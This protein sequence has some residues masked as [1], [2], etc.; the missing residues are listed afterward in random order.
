M[1]RNTNI[2]AHFYLSKPD[3]DEIC[4]RMC[5]LF[6][7]FNLHKK[8][9]SINKHN[10]ASLKSDDWQGGQKKVSYMRV[11]LKKKHS[12]RSKILKFYS[13]FSLIYDLLWCQFS[14]SANKRKTLDITSNYRFCRIGKK[15]YYIPLY[16]CEITQQIL[17]HTIFNYAT[18]FDFLLRLQ[19]LTNKS[20]SQSC[21]K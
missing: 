7:S 11:K 20:F 5:P 2:S 13:W 1:T 14:S 19:C 17:L 3:T 18:I 16:I 6:K 12:L 15:S 8:S 4:A 9:T 21:A 10:V